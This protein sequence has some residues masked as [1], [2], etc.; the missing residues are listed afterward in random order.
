MCAWVKLPR[1]SRSRSKRCTSTLRRA[2][3]SGSLSATRRCNWP[4]VRSASQT[5]PMPPRP[6]SCSSRYGPTAAPGVNSEGRCALAAGAVNSGKRSIRS[7]V[8]PAACLASN[9]RKV[10][11]SRK[12]SPCN[13][14]IQ[15]SR[16]AG[17]RSKACSSRS[18]SVRSSSGFMAPCI[19]NPVR[20]PA[21]KA[22]QGAASV[23]KSNNRAFSQSRRT[24][25]SDR[26]SACAISA[27]VRPP[28]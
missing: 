17:S 26:L 10:G 2:C 19:R 11:A 28:K 12:A 7:P 13:E 24:V 6:S 8:S 21:I 20:K 27:S 23:A 18:D 5:S 3:S 25:R 9:S 1:M 15:A 22:D 14:A 16:S 4:S